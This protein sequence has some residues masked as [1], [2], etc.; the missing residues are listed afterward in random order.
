MKDVFKLIGVILGIIALIYLI[1]ALFVPMR[2]VDKAV[3]REVI[4][5]SQ[6]Y[7][8][9]QR[10]SLITFYQGYVKTVGEE[11]QAY[12]GQMCEIAS[13]IPDTDVPTYIISTL[14]L[15]K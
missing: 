9:T 10:Q 4:E 14:K 3:D 5:Q 11:K 8:T 7:V 6:Q 2:V 12:L 15:C 1:Y 13:N